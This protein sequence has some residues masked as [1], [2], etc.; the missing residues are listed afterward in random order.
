VVRGGSLALAVNGQASGPSGNARER[1]SPNDPNAR[2]R[3]FM[4]V[5]AEEKLMAEEGIDDHHVFPAAYLERRG[6]SSTRARDCVLNRTPVDRTTNQ[7]IGARAP[8]DYLNEIRS[9]PGFPF[10]EVLASHSLPAGAG[11]PLLLDNYQA[12]LDWRQ[13]WLWNVIRRVTG[14]STAAD[15]EATEGTLE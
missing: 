11:S 3:L 8:S 9:T 5:E 13:Y 15:L 6:V 10:D 4:I 1:A 12:F 2:Q 14:V 7:M